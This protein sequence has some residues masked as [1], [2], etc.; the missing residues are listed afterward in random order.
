MEKVKLIIFDLDGTLVNSQDFIE[1]AITTAFQ[2][3]NLRAPP[4]E[5]I[6]S[7]IGLS[8]T[9][10]FK[11]L[12]KNLSDIQIKNLVK[13]FK[14]CYNTFSQEKIL[15]PLYPGARNFLK[16]LTKE[17]SLHL[18]IAT[19]KGKLGLLQILRAHKIE[20]LFSGFQTSDDNPSKPNPEM[21]LKLIK[22]FNTDPNDTLMI[23]DTDFDI[24]MAKNAAI[25]S[26]GV[27][28]GYHS[29]EKLASSNPNIIVK[30]FYDLER[31][32]FKFISG[33]SV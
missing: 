1:D 24:I 33:N 23:G 18:A 19:G 12:N 32:I 25:S 15:S 2:S 9:E 16:R 10:A 13:A 28:W 30:N 3:E 14:N 29:E 7:I 22:E 17:N 20:K 5:E 6:L 11:R 4:L 27:S 8:L 31:E 21:L 26:I